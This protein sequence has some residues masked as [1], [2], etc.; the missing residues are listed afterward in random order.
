VAKQ[1]AHCGKILPSDNTRYCTKCGKTV[2]L[3]RPIKRSLSGEPPAW[4][5]Q[6]ESSFT[7]PLTN[8]PLRE[9]PVKVGEQEK[10]EDLSLL[11]NNNGSIEDEEDVVD[12]LPTRPLSVVGSPRIDAQ[13]PTTSNYTEESIDD[14]E[15]VDD[16]PTMP[17]IASLPEILPAQHPSPSRATGNGNVAHLN[18]IEK[19]LTRPLAA[20]RQSISPTAGNHVQQHR[21]ASQAPLEPVY[22]PVL[23]RP[24]TPVP[25]PQPQ[26]PPA[27]ALRQTPPV[28]MPVPPV[29]HPKRK[30]RQRLMLVFVLLFILLPGGVIA[31]LIVLQPFAVPEITKTTQAFQNAHL[32][33]SLQYPQQWTAEVHEP[34]GTVYFYD[35]NHTDQMNIT[36]V[37]TGGQSINQYISQVAG[38]L[39]MTGQKTEASLSFAGALWQQAQGNVQQS[40]ASYTAT[41]LVTVHDGR[42]YTILQLAPSTTYIHEDQLVF[43]TMRSSF[44]FL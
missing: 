33:I 28:S 12:D 43:S 22:R 31:W 29:A 15:I 9:L 13:P 11:E 35:D 30:S 19:I 21:Q 3:S 27:Q 25:F 7:K 24:V 23:Q 36:V 20:Q 5:K 26:L 32:G 42:Y 39:G 16:L 10:T 18:E 4:M 14:E 40:G 34:K 8:I 6:L 37:A 38:S 2:P 1:C 17:L 44:Q 41:L